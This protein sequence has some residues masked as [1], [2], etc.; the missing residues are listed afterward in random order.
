MVLTT[1][2]KL[3]I[4]NLK[5]FDASQSNDVYDALSWVGLKIQ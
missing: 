2:E 4:L 3:K 5:E 1:K